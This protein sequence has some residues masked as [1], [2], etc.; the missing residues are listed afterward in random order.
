MSEPSVA[1]A[2]ASH[3]RPLRLRW[4][5]NA[6]LEQ[7]APGD[8]FEVL[9]AHDPSDADTEHVLSKRPL[10]A[11]G[12]LRTVTFPPHSAFPGAGRN[13]AWRAT[14][15][16]L[17]LFT[18]DDCRPD[19]DWAAR[20]IAAA[21]AHPGT[22]IQGQTLPDPDE[23]ATLVGAP[24]TETMLVT[25]PTFWAP[26]RNIAYSR[27]VLVQAGGFDERL[28]VGEDTDLA[29]R[30]RRAGARVLA[31]PDMLVYHAVEA[32]LAWGDGAS[33]GALA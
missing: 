14:S 17:I 4:L 23:S 25:P 33:A 6:L 8:T 9:V 13:E 19:R 1:V 20:A 15:A 22:I 21:R 11:C 30:A 16:E 7:S 32:H 24:W 10:R 18:D 2:I 29:V 31:A 12:R 26:T 28:R 3:D 27:S 5:L